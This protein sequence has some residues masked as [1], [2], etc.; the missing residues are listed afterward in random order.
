MLTAPSLGYLLLSPMIIVFAAAV[1][2]VL[3][4][5]FMGKTH[6]AAAQLTI[7]IGALLLA[8]VQLW[9]IRDLSSTTAAVNSV[10]IDKAG[11]FLQATVV[12]LALI[13]V[14]LIADQE[15]FTAQASAVPGSNE[16]AV[17]LLQKNQQTEIFPLFLFAVGG[18]M[19]FPVAT[20]LITLFVALEVFSLPLYLLAGLS[21]RRR[22]L[23]QEA[24]LKYFLLGAYASA[25][26]L[27]GAAFLYGYAGT[28]SL[29]GISAAAGS[30]NEVFLLIGIIFVSI[31]LLFK[32]SAVPFH[33]WT[34]DVYQGAPTPITAFMAACTKV[35]AFGALL[36]I[37]YVGFAEA[38]S[39]WQPIVTVIAIL[40]M[41]LGSVVAIA[42]RDVK[43]MLAY[44]SIAHA[45]F[46]L[47]GVVALSKDGLAASLF[48]LLAY[49]LTTLAAFGIIGLVRDSTGEVTDLNRWVGLGKKSPL[50]GS[51]FAFLLLSFAGIPLTSGFVGKF[52]IFSAAYQS[53]NIPIV[54]SGVLASAIAAFFYIRVI[55]MIF[56]TDP[57]NDS[58]SV[59]I[60]SVKSKISIS[61]ATVASMVFGLAPS[62]LL[63]TAT[64]FAT[65]IK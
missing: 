38:Q 58:V 4:E 28:I 61:V 54:V 35:A 26:F 18:M 37:F 65:F 21:R 51:V 53:G 55:I 15:N 16:E 6:R 17:A 2:G 33:S 52:A 46:L 1:I 22:L 49:G 44:S 31:G 57:V 43:R 20:D 9:R 64:N 25:F 19:L 63:T 50:V 45:G 40:T 56:F 27:F 13:A 36:R 62:L 14:L 30:A 7:S 11:I 8:L 59:I 12:I 29:V 10:T 3:V 32:I 48:Y 34:P 47:S 23:S 41:V 5:A 42:Q 60:P 39:M 24:A